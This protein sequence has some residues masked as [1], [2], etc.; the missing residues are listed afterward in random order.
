M[1]TLELTLE[2]AIE[3]CKALLGNEHRMHIIRILS[4]GP[5]NVKELS[6]SLCTLPH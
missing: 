1:R 3:I 2:E 6:E 5:K 4:E